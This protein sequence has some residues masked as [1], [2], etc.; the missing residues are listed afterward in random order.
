VVSEGQTQV[1]IARTRAGID[2]PERGGD[3][4]R[5]R[6]VPDSLPVSVPVPSTA[7][8]GIDPATVRAALSNVMDP[9]LPMV[10]IVDLGMIGA[11]DVADPGP[12]DGSTAAIRVE[13]LPT[14][15]G[16]PALD[17]IRAAIT[18]RLAALGLPV[19]VETTFN[20]PWTTE[21]VTFAGRAALNAAGIA[22]PSAPADVRCPFCRSTRIV[23]D[24]AFGPTQCRSLYYCRDC[25]QPF[26][27]MKLV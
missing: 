17:I 13:L 21:R 2:V 26:E 1:S 27:A 23:M 6:E 11:V 9:E 24:S 25:R 22:E 19:V 16:C 10:S 20:P 5:D 4:E 18:D 14:Y 15:I 7:G 8:S 12:G 3:P